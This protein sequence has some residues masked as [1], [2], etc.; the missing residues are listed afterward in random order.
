MFW[1][2]MCVEVITFFFWVCCWDGDVCGGSEVGI[3]VASKFVGSS[4]IDLAFS[5]LDFIKSKLLFFDGDS[6]GRE[7]KL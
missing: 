2:E 6:R 1:F 7:R 5:C 3:M 4:C